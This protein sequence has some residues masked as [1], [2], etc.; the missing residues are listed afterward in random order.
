[1]VSHK[2]SF[3]A[4]P[5]PSTPIHRLTCALRD[6]LHLAD[7]F[8]VYILLAALVANYAEGRPL[9]L[10][11]VG[12]PS[13]GK[14]ELLNTLLALPGV[15]EAG[16]MSSEGAFLSGSR[17]KERTSESTGGLLRQI[18]ARGALV[19]KEFGSILSMPPD[20]MHSIIGALREIYD[21]RWSRPIGTDGGRVEHWQGKLA[22]LT[23]STEAIDR[24]HAVLTELGER[25][26]YY[27]YEAPASDG[28]SECYRA[29][30]R[31]SPETLTATLQ[32]LV[33]QFAQELALDWTYPPQLVDPSIGDH[34]RL[35]AFAQL[36]SHGR[37]SVTRDRW[38]KEILS[39]SVGE[40][41]T[42]LATVLGQLLSA[43]RYIGVSQ[44]DSWRILRKCAFDSIPGSRRSALLALFSGF[45]STRDIAAHARVSNATAGR[46][47]EELK[48][49]SLVSHSPD[50]GWSISSWAH[51]RLREAWP[52]RMLWNGTH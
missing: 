46:A 21:G 15:I 47:L 2:A 29:L 31:E 26:L 7:P 17:R 48:L 11:L 4:T 16:P 28:W 13:C 35:I 33:L 49:Y 5:F 39:A 32:S 27:R 41:P 36:A 23:G 40:Y 38:S 30:T 44:D 37:S 6:H 20:R 45:H 12:P 10:M 42:R 9:W 50:S 25:F 24:H 18:G 22:L 43:L 51:D 34:Q 52:N 14:S 1:M 19:L 8:P 3:T